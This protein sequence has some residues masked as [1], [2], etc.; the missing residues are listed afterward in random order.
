MAAFTFGKYSL[1]QS[2]QEQLTRLALS[3]SDA[4]LPFLLK[5]FLPPRQGSTSCMGEASP[6]SRVLHPLFSTEKRADSSSSHSPTKALCRYLHNYNMVLH[7]LTKLETVI[8]LRSM[9]APSV[10]SHPPGVGC[11]AGSVP[12]QE[13]SLLEVFGQTLAPAR[14]TVVCHE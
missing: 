1:S 7:L 12:W 5:P 8:D 14:D 9:Q 10:T 2:L 11:P 13:A 4:P 3:L 6:L